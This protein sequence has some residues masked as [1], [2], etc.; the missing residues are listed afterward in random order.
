VPHG[1][2]SLQIPL[3]SMNFSVTTPALTKKSCGRRDIVVLTSGQRA[4]VERMQRAE[5]MRIAFSAE[6][7]AEAGGAVPSFDVPFILR[8]DLV[9]RVACEM[10]CLLAEDSTDSALLTAFATIVAGRVVFAATARTTCTGPMSTG[11]LDAI[12]NHIRKHLDTPIEVAELSSVAALT[13]RQFVQ[14]FQAAR[15]L[16]PRAYI[17]QHRMQRA[18][19]LLETTVLSI[20]EVALEVGLTASHFSRSFARYF[21]MS[22]RAFRRHHLPR[23]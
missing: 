16:T 4:T 10:R 8:D 11:Q 22:P 18:A 3:E 7:A 19:H 14:R 9:T 15:G 2:L 5:V 12:D 17:A 13:P 23:S 21:G 1:A 6:F 20:T